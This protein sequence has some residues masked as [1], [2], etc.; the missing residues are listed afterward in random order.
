RLAR[1]KVK[2]LGLE[3]FGVVHAFGSSH[4]GT[5]LI[6]KAYFEHEAYVPLLQ[7][8]YEGWGEIESQW[9]TKLLHQVGF[10]MIG[11]PDGAEKLGAVQATARKHAVPL[12]ILD[13]RACRE[14]YPALRCPPGYQGILEPGA[15]YLLAEEAVRAMSELAVRHG[16]ELR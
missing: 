16:A 15:G 10:L 14:R 8:A 2:V 7:R 1:R 13:E 6:R 5:R 9:G 12:Q 11:P 3:Q 4:G